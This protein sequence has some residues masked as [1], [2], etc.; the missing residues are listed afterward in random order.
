MHMK[1][2]RFPITYANVALGLTIGAL[3][4][5]SATQRVNAKENNSSNPTGAIFATS[6]TDGGRL[7]IQRSPTLGANVSIALKIDGK[8][9]GTLVRNRT[10]DKYI[11]PG[12]HT[13]TASP[14]RSGGQWHGTLDVRVGGTYSYT[15]SY[16]VDS[17]VLTPAKA[18]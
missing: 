4:L 3:L 17:L 10:Y 16:N 15:A 5:A 8:A 18:R 6:A 7:L 2:T 12:R 9:A 14:N 1:Q 11:T 13:L